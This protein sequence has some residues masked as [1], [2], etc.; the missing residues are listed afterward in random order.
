MQYISCSL[1]V[2]LR[3]FDVV[4]CEERDDEAVF[5]GVDSMVLLVVNSGPV[6]KCFDLQGSAIKIRQF[7]FVLLL[8]P[9]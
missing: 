5:P 2:T 1:P 9:F 7:W 6:P 4:A 3:V 8:Q